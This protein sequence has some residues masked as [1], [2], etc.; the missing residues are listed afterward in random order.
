MLMLRKIVFF[1]FVFV[2]LSLFAQQDYMVSSYVRGNFYNRG[3]IS[4]ESLRASDDL[5]FLNVHP[6]KDGSLSFE[7]TDSTNNQAKLAAESNAPDGTLFVAE[8]Q[9]GG[10]G[11]RKS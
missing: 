11:R 3:R 10:R 4:T 7:K 6:N 2:G 1:L 9:T 5:I 8:C